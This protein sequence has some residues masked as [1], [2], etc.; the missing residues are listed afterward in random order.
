[1]AEVQALA[2]DLNEVQKESE[3]THDLVRTFYKQYITVSTAFQADSAS[4]AQAIT[5]DQQDIL[6]LSSKKD[7]LESKACTEV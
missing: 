2:A 5:E 7:S 1:M 4:V 6:D 3:N